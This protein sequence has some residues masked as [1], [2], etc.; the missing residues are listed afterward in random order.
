MMTFLSSYFLLLFS[1]DFPKF[2]GQTVRK[3]ESNLSYVL[4][5]LRAADCCC[6]DSFTIRRSVFART[7][8]A[9]R[10]VSRG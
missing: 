7:S 8:R 1:A 10:L 3:F 5:P 2:S 4:F 9:R 6:D